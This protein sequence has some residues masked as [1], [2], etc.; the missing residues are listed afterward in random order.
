[1]NNK[2][3][4]KEQIYTYAK[5]SPYI[6]GSYEVL[7]SWVWQDHPAL[8]INANIISSG[9]KKSFLSGDI[10]TAAK[11]TYYDNSEET[12]AL[13]EGVLLSVA[14]NLYQ[15]GQ[16]QEA[17]VY[18]KRALTLTDSHKAY[19]VNQTIYAISA[20]T[21][22]SM[23][24]F[25]QAQ[26]EL[27]N[28]DSSWSDN[29]LN[30]SWT[31]V[32]YLHLSSLPRDEKSQSNDYEIANIL[33]T[34]LQSFSNQSKL[35]APYQLECLYASFLE[36]IGQ[37]QL[38]A[39]ITESA[40]EN[41]EAVETLVKNQP[42]TNT[43]LT[44]SYYQQGLDFSKQ[45]KTKESVISL[46]KA[47]NKSPENKGINCVLS[48]AYMSYARDFAYFGDI[49]ESKNQSA[50]AKALCQFDGIN[51]IDADIALANGK[52]YM[53][54]G[55]WEKARESFK[56]I[57]EQKTPNKFKLSTQLVEDTYLAPT[58]L[59][60]LN[61]AR[62]WEDK[63]PNVT[64][65]NCYFEDDSDKCSKI[66]IFDDER[67]IGMALAD[68]SRV[69]FE[70]E[71][72]KNTVLKDT[73]N[74]GQLDTFEM[75]EG[76]KRRVLVE[77]D[78]DYRLDADI[79]FNEK[80]EKIEEKR[81]SG[82][83]LIRIPYAAIA[84]DPNDGSDDYFSNP[85]PYIKISLNDTYVG[86][87]DTINNTPTPYW[88]Q[89]FVQ[90][91]RKDDCIYI[92]MWDYDP[93]DPDDRIDDFKTCNFSGSETLYGFNNR[94]FIQLEVK[95]T[96]LPEGVYNVEST[97]KKGNPYSNFVSEDPKLQAFLD[98]AKKADENS[99]TVASIAINVAPYIITPMLG[100]EGITKSFTGFII[101]Q[102]I[103]LGIEKVLEYQLKNN[104][105][106]NHIVNPI[107]KQ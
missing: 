74:N 91:Y 60:K 9:I 29:L 67:R 63:V 96:T 27:T 31:A 26:L 93:L 107:I 61:E 78:G 77:S 18:A 68:M 88:E 30:K 105:I 47:H 95:P 55:K 98:R 79:L 44:N 1:M 58:R 69:E 65:M 16:F 10:L 25:D 39:N 83:A 37:V 52:T 86:K 23:G 22:A 34:Y 94:A 57:D 28:I 92:T 13:R 89:A 19:Q 45:Q 66:E 82:R 90:N 40:I 101:N 46:E 32:V 48:A 103:D 4:E 54:Y 43:L 100:I 11:Y 21:Q 87:T 56:E 53:R 7:F 8:K 84:D 12:L 36:K 35:N 71:N 72:G 97:E 104:D 15:K 51:D 99:K 76:T 17:L 62:K 80:G 42:S 38:N 24:K 49:D 106:E 73:D 75:T 2:I 85:D 33:K 64:G 59:E 20:I 3:T 6:T 50:K 81:Y 41:L 14:Q 70:E 5:M 102:G